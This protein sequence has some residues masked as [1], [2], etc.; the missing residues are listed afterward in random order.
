MNEEIGGAEKTRYSLLGPRV[1]KNL[2]ARRFEAKYAETASEA[3]A[4]AMRW[5][6]GGSTV[7]WGGGMT[8]RESGLIDA[9]Y[10]RA[11]EVKILDR[12][13]ASTPMERSEMMRAA[14]F[15]DVYLTSFNAV[16]EDGCLFNIDGGGNRVAAIAYGPKSVLAVVG[17]NKV[18]R[19][20]EEAALRARSLAAPTNVARLRLER[21]G[22]AKTGSCSDCKGEECI[23]TYLVETRMSNPKGRIKILLVGENLGF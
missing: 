13:V 8:L 12:D 4:L 10:K 18:A 22:C 5:I 7:A 21:T 9:V 15:A 19:T 3:V 11:A 17:M 1:A 23:C 20:R 14:F 16:S 2:E 6:P